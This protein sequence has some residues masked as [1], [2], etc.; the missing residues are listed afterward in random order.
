M[1]STVIRTEQL[2]RLLFPKSIAVVGASAS[3]E[4][5]GSQFV[6]ALRGFPGNLYPINPTATEIQG[7]IAY[8]DLASLPQAPDLVAVAVPAVA[9]PSVIRASA[10]AG[11]GGALVIGGGFS[12]SGEVGGELQEQMLS[13]ARAGALRVLGPNTSGFFNPKNR[14]FATF[15]PGTETIAPG[16]VAVVAQSGGVNLTL[17]F[18]LSRVGIGVS[19]AIGLGNAMDVDASDVLTIL[20]GDEATK[21]IAL[22]VEGV[23]YGRRLF[24]TLSAVT[25]RTPVVVLTVGRGD[26]SAFAESHTGALLGAF[27]VKV[28]A[29]RQAGAIVVDSSDELVAACM[30]LSF[31]RLPALANPGVGLVTAQAGPGLLIVDSLRS[32]GICLPDLKDAT[33]EKIRELLPP[34]TYMRN[35]VDT[36]RPSAHF[37]QI[38]STVAADPAIDLI[39][40]SA[41]NEPQVLNPAVTLAAAQL[42]KP[43]LF[44]GLG[45]VGDIDSVLASVRAA[46]FPTF[47]SPEQMVAGVKALVKDAQACHRN[48]LKET[49][50]VPLPGPT[51]RQWSGLN[52]D[53]AKDVLREIGIRIPE[54]FLCVDRR[55]AHSALARASGKVVVKVVDAAILHKTE[56]GGVHVGIRDTA[57]LDHALDTIDAIDGP[58]RPYLIE[59]MAPD[60]LELIVGA[61][62]DPNFGPV[63]LVGLGGVAAEALKDVSRRLAPITRSEAEL[64]ISELRGHEL[65]DGWRGGAKL[66]GTAVA[67]ALVGLSNLI[68]SNEGILEIEINPLRVYSNGCLALDA[69]IVGKASASDA[70]T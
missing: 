58:W 31:N 18:M 16:P 28:A 64:M 52:E 70:H 20:A 23:T 36:G 54:K 41:L 66:D 68:C 46:G 13:A 57:G 44:S 1:S 15:A 32:D 63:V 43:L 8:P 67:E 61:I 37:T 2:K 22:H 35:P 42:T 30:A 9:T 21:V 34:I 33:V 51:R 26:S 55:E 3:F 29:L 10:A 47:L 69:L 19:H 50:D 45:A 6:H 25:R 12:E 7:F 65:L 62:R 40:V 59:A 27:E 5:A 4:K 38:V 39:C 56:V 48:S 17:A 14:C 60:G 53:Q 49:S 11:A 24:D